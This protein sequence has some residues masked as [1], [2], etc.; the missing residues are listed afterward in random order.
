VF[1]PAAVPKPILEKLNADMVKVLSM[2]D[3]QQRLG[4]MGLD[5]TPSTS[6]QLASLVSSETIR[7]GKVVRDAGLTAD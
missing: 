1:S 3:V 2:A 6:A 5:I 7:W 4:E